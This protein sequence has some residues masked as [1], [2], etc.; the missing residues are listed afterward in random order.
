MDFNSQEEQ[1][2]NLEYLCQHLI[3]GLYELKYEELK[4]QNLFT[5]WL[6][7]NQYLTVPF[8]F[9]KQNLGSKEPPK[10]ILKY[11]YTFLVNAEN[12]DSITM[13]D[14]FHYKMKKA[15]DNRNYLMS[16]L[17]EQCTSIIYQARKQVKTLKFTNCDLL[18]HYTMNL[19]IF[20]PSIETLIID[21]CQLHCTQ[22]LGQFKNLKVLRVV[23]S[24]VYDD[25]RQDQDQ[26]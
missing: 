12:L 5:L 6:G 21:I 19:S 11:F 10:I 24:I 4:Q 1:L 25:P 9:R 23:N 15:H 20:Y 22:N 17:T 7:N 18:Q 8:F 13:S 16:N 2:I 14:C 3:W 26:N